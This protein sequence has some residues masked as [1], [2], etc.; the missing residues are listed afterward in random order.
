MAKGENFANA[1][2]PDEE[3][4]AV[5][6]GLGERME[7]VRL[8]YGVCVTRLMKGDGHVGGWRR[9]RAG[10]YNRGRRGVGA[11]LILE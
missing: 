3:H 9:A 10:G 7:G 1:E 6:K 2:R 8:W 4:Y 5:W 11:Y